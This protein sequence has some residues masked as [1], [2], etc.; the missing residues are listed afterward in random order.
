MR[1]GLSIALLLALAASGCASKKF[2][3]ARVDPVAQRV[4]ALERQNREQ[5][6]VGK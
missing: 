5:R 1:S 3:R 2:V 6:R 4:D